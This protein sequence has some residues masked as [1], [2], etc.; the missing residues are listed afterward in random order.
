MDM[1]NTTSS[2]RKNT[3]RYWMY[4]LISTIACVALLLFKPEWFWVALPF[5]LT[6]LVMAF[7]AM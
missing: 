1:T 7:D 6:S 5:V 4:F 3:G 2:T